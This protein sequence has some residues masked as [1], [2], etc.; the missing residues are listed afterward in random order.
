MMSQRRDDHSETSTSADLTGLRCPKCDYDL[1]GLTQNCCP[2]CGSRFDPCVLRSVEPRSKINTDRA[3]I[4]IF[5]VATATF[6]FCLLVFVLV[7]FEGPVRGILPWIIPY[8]GDLVSVAILIAVI[9]GMFTGS[10]ALF[11]MILASFR[12]N[13]RATTYCAFA[14]LMVLL[15][16]GIALS[17]AR[18][19]A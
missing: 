15:A 10:I 2:E 3:A 4:F 19:L 12:D 13:G 11:V 18:Y 16:A 8:L 7:Q 17:M 6:L 9:G 5:I 14:L 1:T